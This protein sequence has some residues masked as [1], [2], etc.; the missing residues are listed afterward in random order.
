MYRFH[1][2]DTFLEFMYDMCNIIP[3]AYLPDCVVI[4]D[5]L[6]KEASGRSSDMKGVTT[7]SFMTASKVIKIYSRYQWEVMQEAKRLKELD[8]QTI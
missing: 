3:P 5:K 6:Y 8:A 1:D 2:K 4:S 7:F